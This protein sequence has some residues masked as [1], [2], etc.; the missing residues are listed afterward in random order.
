MVKQNIVK[1][2]FCLLSI[3]FSF[4]LSSLYS[5]VVHDLSSN[6][7]VREFFISG[8]YKSKMDKVIEPIDMLGIEYIQ[9]E[10]LFNSN[11]QFLNGQVIKS[12]DGKHNINVVLDD[13]SFAVA[14]LF[15]QINS[16]KIQDSYFLLSVTDGAKLYV[17]GTQ[18]HAYYGNNYYLKEKQIIVP[19]RGGNND[20]V[21]KIPNKDW[22]WKLKLKILDQDAGKA[23]SYEKNEENEYFQF[24]NIKLQSAFGESNHNG[25]PLLR[26]K[27]GSFPTLVLDKPGLAKKYLGGGYNI[28][29]RWFDTDLIEVQYPKNPGR[30]G[31]YAEII[32]NNEKKLKRSG[33]LFCE[34]SDWMAWNNRLY[35]DLDYFPFNNIPERIW[36]EHRDAIRSYLGFSTLKSFLLQETDIILLAFLDEMYKKGF[37]K[38]RKLTPL[39]YDGDYHAALKQK[40]LVKENYYLELASPQIIKKKSTKLKSEIKKY[41]KQNPAFSEKMR[42]L[43][44]EWIADGGSPFDMVIA[45]DG[46]IIFHE[47]F[48]SDNYGEFTINT[49]TEIASITKLFTGILFAQFV[50]Q[51]IIGIDDPVGKYLPDFPME[52][53]RAITM[54][55]CFTHTSGFY[56]HGLFDGVH[57]H[58]L[59]NTLFQ[60]VKNDTV[61][62]LYRYNGM[63]YDLAGKVMESVTGK[64]IFRLFHEYLYEPLGMKNTI[65]D[66]DLGYS[67]HTTAYDL[68]ILAQ[69]ILNKGTYD[70][71]RYFSET[72]YEQIL[73][74]NLK[75]YY[76]EL[77]FTNPW[78]EGRP[79]GIGTT[80]QEWEISDEETGEKRHL[81]SKNVIG[82]GSATSSVFRI[83]LDN[84]IIITQSRRKGRS[85]FGEHFLKIYKLIDKKLVLKDD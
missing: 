60:A 35:S 74:K 38:D 10:N 31:Y 21:L 82:H 57:N 17:N 79:R 8:P 55:Q 49:P 9:N 62:T 81:L 39:I 72:T 6:S 18:L 53:P 42:E 44:Q 66:W 19:L 33:T 26:F 1:N 65:H 23:Y 3:F 15:F 27:V 77:V 85:R 84:N 22:D 47:S 41:E 71:K 51:N 58:W 37:P 28:H 78:D 67:V 63:G 75:S 40:I 83:D 70:G 64:S 13:T 45:Q 73:P 2:I 36:F 12:E 14:Y 48:G 76:P 54:R 50:D 46:N 20:V 59:E 25:I 52:G 61:G 11:S 43:C 32:G 4:L 30:Y 29:V 24:L 16:E 56:G 80:M 68:A 5:Q 7:F 69:M 34:P